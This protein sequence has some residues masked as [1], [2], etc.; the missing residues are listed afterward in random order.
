M[1][2]LLLECDEHAPNHPYL[3]KVLVREKSSKG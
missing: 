1:S 3:K 2:P